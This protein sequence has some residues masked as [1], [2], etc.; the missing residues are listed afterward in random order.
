M[1]DYDSDYDSDNDYYNS[2][3]KAKGGMLLAFYIIASV[4]A[5]WFLLI[6]YK[7]VRINLTIKRRRK[8]YETVTDP[9]QRMELQPK[10]SGLLANRLKGNDEFIWFSGI[11]SISGVRKY[12]YGFV[13]GM[14]IGLGFVIVGFVIQESWCLSFMCVGTVF[15]FG[16]GI[17]CWAGSNT[18]TRIVFGLTRTRALIVGFRHAYDYRD[19]PIQNWTRFKTH[20]DNAESLIITTDHWITTSRDE[21]GNVQTHHH[22]MD[23]GICW[24][25]EMDIV[26]RIMKEKITVT[27]NQEIISDEEMGK[28]LNNLF[29]PNNQ[30]NLGNDNIVLQN[31]NQNDLNL[32]MNMNNMNNINNMNM[33]TNVNNEI[34]MGVPMQNTTDFNINYN[35]NDNDN[36]LN[37]GNEY[38]PDFNYIGTNENDF[39]MKKF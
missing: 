12:F 19:Y 5:C 28:S 10:R 14:S 8:I 13:I 15:L 25:F 33:N 11:T 4:D 34:N 9:K 27:T 2:D 1:S 21:N 32:G 38:N 39:E 16:V 36:D 31:Q 35:Y 17:T 18:R 22:Y 6:L 30:T 3:S 24:I 20:W 29:D 7:M 37:G 26:R 23:I